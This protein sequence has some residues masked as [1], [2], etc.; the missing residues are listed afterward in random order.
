MKIARDKAY[1]RLVKLQKGKLTLHQVKITRRHKKSLAMTITMVIGVDENNWK[2]QSGT[3][4]GVLYYIKRENES[5]K[6]KCSLRCFQCDT[7]VHEYSCTCRD[8]IVLG[9]ICKHIHLMLRKLKCE[10]QKLLA[11]PKDICQSNKPADNLLSSNAILNEV[12]LSSISMHHLR[13]DISHKLNQ[14][15]S[16][17]LTCNDEEILRT[18]ASHLNTAL[19]Y[20]KLNTIQ[21][22]M[23]KSN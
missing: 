11:N 6:E 17:I 19:N 1:E 15:S 13:T 7:S 8:S 5:C 22:P 21:S 14:L 18:V 20:T 4:D 10:S 2:I 16:I 3:D 12:Q 23:C 9:T